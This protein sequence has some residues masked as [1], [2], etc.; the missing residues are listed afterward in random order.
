MQESILGTAQLP[1]EAQFQAWLDDLP[2]PVADVVR[3]HSPFVP[4][5][6]KASGHTVYI[7]RFQGDEGGTPS[8]K[9]AVIAPQ[10]ANPGQAGDLSFDGIDP[11]DLHA[12]AS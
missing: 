4:H 7:A 9:L 10:S 3:T 6:L 2:E 5:R 12:L 11:D 1:T 8:V